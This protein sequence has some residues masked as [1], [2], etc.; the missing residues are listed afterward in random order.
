MRVSTR[1]PGLEQIIETYYSL[2]LASGWRA[3]ADYQFNSPRHV[4]SHRLSVA[5]SHTLMQR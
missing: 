3:S 5:K 1:H 2:P 4:D